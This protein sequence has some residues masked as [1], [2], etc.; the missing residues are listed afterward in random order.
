L[1]ALVAVAV[2]VEKVAPRGDVVGRF[3]GLVQ[4]AAGVVVVWRGLIEG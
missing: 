2:L 4:F 1:V 3:A